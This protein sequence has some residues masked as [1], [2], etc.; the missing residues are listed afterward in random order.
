MHALTATTL[1]RPAAAGRTRVAP[2]RTCDR[3]RDLFG[4]ANPGVWRHS[5]TV[6]MRPAFAL[7]AIAVKAYPARR[8]PRGSP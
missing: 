8:P 5:T 4:Q 1:V 7:P 2:G 3:G 6:D